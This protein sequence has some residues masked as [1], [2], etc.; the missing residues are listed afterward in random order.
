MVDIRLPGKVNSNF[1]GARPVHQIIS[2][3]KWSRPSRLSVKKSLSHHEDAVCATDGLPEHV[4]L[5]WVV[6]PSAGRVD[7]LDAVQGVRGAEDVDL[8][9]RSSRDDIS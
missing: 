2:M 7:Q 1:H 8:G 5:Q 3:I 4:E 9:L 6:G